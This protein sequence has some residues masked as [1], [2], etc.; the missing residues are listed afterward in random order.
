MSTRSPTVLTKRYL[1]QVS[2]GGQLV[3]IQMAFLAARQLPSLDFL[4]AQLGRTI[5]IPLR[6]LQLSN[7]A[8]P[9]FDDGHRDSLALLV[10]YLRH[11]DFLT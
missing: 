9:S 2:Q 1:S 7:E 3:A 10:K 11:T 5:A 8:G 4:E 6:R